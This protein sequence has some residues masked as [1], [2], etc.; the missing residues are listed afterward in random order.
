MLQGDESENDDANEE[1][2]RDNGALNAFITRWK[3]DLVQAHKHGRPLD[4]K[5]WQTP[6][7]PFPDPL[8]EAGNLDP[9]KWALKGSSVHFVAWHIFHSHILKQQYNG[10]N[11]PPCPCCESNQNVVCDGWMKAPRRVVCLDRNDYLFSACYRC[12]CPSK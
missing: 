7:Q 10:I 8:M 1:V 11:Y 3:D 5:L 4:K 6:C 12:H 9:E 2:V